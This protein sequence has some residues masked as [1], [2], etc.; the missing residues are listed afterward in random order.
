MVTAVVVLTKALV[1]GLVSSTLQH[2][3]WDSLQDQVTRKHGKFIPVLL[4]YLPK[5]GEKSHRFDIMNFNGSLNWRQ[6]I[7]NNA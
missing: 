3:K 5:S 4:L 2:K 7:Y 6:R 1:S